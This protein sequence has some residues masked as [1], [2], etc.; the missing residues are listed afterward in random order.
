M[1]LLKVENTPQQQSQCFICRR[2]PDKI[3]RQLNGCD[4]GVFALMFAEYQARDAPF[5]FDQRHMEYFRVKVV[6]DIMSQNIDL[7]GLSA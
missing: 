5:T 3:P 2:S 1:E 7:P 4:C 6:A